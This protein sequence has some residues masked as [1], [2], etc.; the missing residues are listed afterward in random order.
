MAPETEYQKIELPAIG[1]PIQRSFDMLGKPLLR[2][3]GRAGHQ[4]DFIVRETAK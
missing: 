4:A 3:L 1:K 2:S